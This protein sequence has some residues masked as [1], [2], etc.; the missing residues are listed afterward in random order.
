MACSCSWVKWGK[1]PSFI[2]SLTALAQDTACMAPARGTLHPAGHFCSSQMPP[3]PDLLPTC[4]PPLVLLWVSTQKSPSPEG[5]LSALWSS[6]PMTS[7][8]PMSGVTWVSAEPSRGIVNDS[9]VWC[10]VALHVLCALPGDL[11][12]DMHVGTD[13]HIA[14]RSASGP[15]T[16][17][18]SCW[19]RSPAWH[20]G[21]SGRITA[22]PGGLTSSTHE[23]VWP[24][25]GF[26]PCSSP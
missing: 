22:S 5:P 4:C 23:K 7:S 21:T 9:F 26:P 14:H 8:F 25:E 11:N 1:S 19:G 20:L 17:T 10:Y 24:R 12:L 16:G 15:G 18:H 2:W 13:T 6:S 3:F